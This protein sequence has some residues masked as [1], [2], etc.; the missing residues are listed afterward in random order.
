VLSETSLLARTRKY[1]Y[2]PFRLCFEQGI[3]DNAKLGG[4]ESVLRLRVDARGRVASSRL[5]STKLKDPNVADCIA[6]RARELPLLRPPSAIDVE[7]K[8]SIWPGDA[9][10]PS[11]EKP[12]ETDSG[13][14]PASFRPSSI[15]E[16][17]K[18][19]ESSFV[20]CYSEGLG[21]DGS[22]WGRIQ[23]HVDL[24]ANGSIRAARE[25]ESRFPDRD[26]SACVVRAVR[27]LTFSSVKA[28][29]NAFEI[30]I[31]LGQPPTP[32]TSSP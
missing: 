4:G 8:V 6:E 19:I 29:S 14:T 16:T 27:Q 23:I 28:R 24:D 30:G 13:T 31:R 26:V 17:V 10:L 12:P 7:L 1:G 18:T 11:L 3:H 32:T 20:E 2:W 15:H 25:N 22:L 21:R 5:V 9:P